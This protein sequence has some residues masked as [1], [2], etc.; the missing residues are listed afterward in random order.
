M[1]LTRSVFGHTHKLWNAVAV[2]D[3]DGSTRVESSG[4][5][6]DG[7]EDFAVAFEAV[8]ITGTPAVRLFYE[9]SYEDVDGSYI[10]PTDVNGTTVPDITTNLADENKHHQTIS[11]PVAKF[12]R[13]VAIGLAT[14]PSDTTITLRLLRQ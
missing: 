10:Q 9:V 11:P 8:S 7:H 6:L 3:S 12:I 14:N 5:S 1:G 2:A 4:L 13:F